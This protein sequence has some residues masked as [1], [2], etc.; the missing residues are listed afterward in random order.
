MVQKGTPG[1]AAGTN[2][3]Q[4]ASVMT[5]MKMSA[6][7]ADSKTLT[8]TLQTSQ[9]KIPSRLQIDHPDSQPQPLLLVARNTFTATGMPTLMLVMTRA[10]ATEDPHKTLHNLMTPV[11]TATP[12]PHNDYIYIF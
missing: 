10:P 11:N 6:E 9:E 2:G 5:S 7:D 4:E 1:I 12:S 3:Q 8:R